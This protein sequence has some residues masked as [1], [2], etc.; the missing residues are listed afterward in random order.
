M[1]RVGHRPLDDSGDTIGVH[2]NTFGGNNG[3]EKE[4]S[5]HGT[6]T[7][8]LCSGFHWLGVLED[9]SV[10]RNVFLQRA[11]RINER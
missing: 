9:L 8:P 10:L 4:S 3:A 6:H 7:F 2:R 5:R 1:D 11:V